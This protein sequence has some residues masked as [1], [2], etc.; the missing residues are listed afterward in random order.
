VK[1]LLISYDLLNKA[2]Y[3]YT[4]LIDYIK[5]YGN[6]AKPLESF[7]L[8]KTDKNISM[9]RDELKNNVSAGDKI[10][11]MDITSVNWATLSISEEV[12]GWMQ[13]NV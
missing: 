5:S 9:V 3:D 1:T 8:I 12:T 11:V 13:S 4:K 7:W 10:I 2:D 6:W